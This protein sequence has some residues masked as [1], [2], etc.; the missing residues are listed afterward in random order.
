MMHRLG[1]ALMMILVLATPAHAQLAA[2]VLPTARSGVIG[3]PATAF[4]TMINTVTTMAHGCSISISR[5]T[6][7]G[8]PTPAFLYQTT[9]PHTNQL[10][11]TPDTPVDIPAGGAQTFLIAATPTDEFLG[12]IEFSFA[13]TDRSAAASLPLVNTLDLVVLLTP[14]KDII[15]IAVTPNNDGIVNIPSGGRAGMF[16]VAMKNV[17]TVDGSGRPFPERESAQSTVRTVSTDICETNATTGQCLAPPASETQR[18]IAVGETVTFAIF[19]S[20]DDVVPFDPATNRIDVSV[21]ELVLIGII[22]KTD[23][24]WGAT[25]VAVRT[26]P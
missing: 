8:R 2:A 24:T 20:S 10:T 17:G 22:T 21:S 19:V 13:C 7:I 1:L 23:F 16:V 15:S 25:S 9:D 26:Q 14:Q 18:R 4:A 12:R 3:K 5:H 6:S 11:G